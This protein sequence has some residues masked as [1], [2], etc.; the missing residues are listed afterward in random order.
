M[1]I[2]SRERSA[3]AVLDWQ[4]CRT[5]S[6]VAPVMST[7]IS[8]LLA[9]MFSSGP[10]RAACDDIAYL[11]FTDA[12]KPEYRDRMIRE[13]L[14]RR[15]LPGEGGHAGFSPATR[16]Q[17]ELAR[18]IVSAQGRCSAE[19]VCSGRGLSHVFAFVRSR[20]ANHDQG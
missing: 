17:V 9:P 7:S 11:Q 16:D 10:M 6:R 13:S 8:P 3:Y 14:H 4:P 2:R 5:M 12:R 1:H 19:D 20:Q 15:V 18:V